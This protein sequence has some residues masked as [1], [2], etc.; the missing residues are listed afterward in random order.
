[1]TLGDENFVMACSERDEW[2]LRY[3]ILRP[4]RLRLGAALA[5]EVHRLV[6]SVPGVLALEAPGRVEV[7]GVPVADKAA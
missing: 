5:D 2:I 6:I 3:K 1:M 4:I 7:L